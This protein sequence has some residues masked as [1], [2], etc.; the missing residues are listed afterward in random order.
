MLQRELLHRAGGQKHAAPG[1]TIRLGQHRGDLVLPEQRGQ[2]ASR[3]LRGTCKEDFHW[4]VTY[5][6]SR[7]RFF[8]LARSLICLSCDRYSTNALPRRWSISCW[9]QTARNPSASSVKGSP[10]SSS[11]RT[12]TFSARHTFS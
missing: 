1:W 5:M 8:S 11:A 4:Q 9:M 6:V 12:V 2:C 7:K 3:K 10:F